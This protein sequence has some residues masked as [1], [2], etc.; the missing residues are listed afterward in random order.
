[1]KS[2]LSLVEVL[3]V[4]AIL[5]ILAAIALPRFQSNSQQ[6]KE[7]AAKSNLR[8]LRQQIEVYAA[9]HNSVPPG[10]PNDDMT[11]SPGFIYFL[12][13]MTKQYHYLSELP[14]N[15][16]NDRKTIKLLR[17]TEDFPAEATGNFGWFYKPLTKSVRLDW[18]GTDSKG[19]SFYDY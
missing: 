12:L 15:P 4:V 18:P 13:Q 17:D 1:M 14:R 9:Q 8:I 6:A 2:A 7:A 5:G 19:A 16:F 11:K 3:I 10:Y